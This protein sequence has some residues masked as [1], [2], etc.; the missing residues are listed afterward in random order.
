M[1]REVSVQLEFLSRGF[2]VEGGLC[3][4]GISVKGRSLSK[5]VSVWGR[6]VSVRGVS[7]S[8]G[9]MSREVSVQGDPLRMITSGP[10]APYWN[11]FLF[12]K[13]FA[14]VNAS[15]TSDPNWS[16]DSVKDHGCEKDLMSVQRMRHVIRGDVMSLP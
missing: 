6:E 12:Y 10:Y 15:P 9:S 8:R 2:S 13:G 5:G 7:L 4:G 3:S 11:A 14:T 1:T 16:R